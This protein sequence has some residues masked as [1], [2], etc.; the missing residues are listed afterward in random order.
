MK[1]ICI[2]IELNPNI[3]N[4]LQ[5]ILPNPI[6]DEEEISLEGLDKLT[7]NFVY[8]DIYDCLSRAKDIIKTN[9]ETLML[10]FN[11]ISR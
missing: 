1:Y 7:D 4:A 5:V 11:S 9:K 3:I 6:I 2:G 8:S 10:F